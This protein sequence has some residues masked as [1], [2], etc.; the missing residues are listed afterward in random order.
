MYS[1]SFHF[2]LILVFLLV[3]GCNQS[4]KKE[5]AG[6]TTQEKNASA[7]A[8][9]LPVLS[10]GIQVS[11]AMGLIMVADKKGFFTSNGVKVEIK[12]FTAGKF[13]LQAFLGGSIDIAVSGEVPVALSALQGNKFRVISQVVERTINEVRVVARRETGL[14]TPEKYFAKKKRKLATSF[15]GGPE[16]YTYN[17]LKRFKIPLESI[18]LISQKPE[19]MPA[20]L[21]SKSVDAVSI[22]DPFARISELQLGADAITFTAPDIYSE[23]Y[24]VNVKQELIDKKSDQLIHFLKA[25]DEASAYI[26]KNEEESKEIVRSFTQLDK[27]VIDGIW[28]NFVFKPAINDLFV[29]YTNAEARWAIETGKFPPE[30][31]IPDFNSILYSKILENVNKNNI[32]L[33]TSLK[34]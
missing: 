16:F 7:D 28:K 4:A 10:V 8:S 24:V 25:L 12:E 13:A 3:A 20:A 1:K 31:R 9:G 27:E 30:T 5:T 14:D 11:P 15:G 29:K 6:Q 17:F 23:L 33:T 22:F 19:D 32:Q 18:E 21:I 26:E 34:K 2:L